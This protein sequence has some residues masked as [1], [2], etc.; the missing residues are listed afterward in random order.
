MT[1]ERAKELLPLIQEYANG[2][3]I[4]CRSPP[5][6]A[7]MEVERPLWADN[8]QYRLKPEVPQY[9]LFQYN[10]GVI[11]VV[12]RHKPAIILQYEHYANRNEGNW[13]TDWIPCPNIKLD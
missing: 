6:T 8:V 3:K 4:E 9:R 1:P 7:W 5:H 2:K 11:G 12:L 13:R 10:S